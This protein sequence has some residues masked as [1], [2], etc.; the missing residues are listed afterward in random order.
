MPRR[1][2]TGTAHRRSGRE[3]GSSALRAHPSAPTRTKPAGPSRYLVLLLSALPLLYVLAVNAWVVDDAYITF[4]TVDNFVHGHGLTWNVD[5]R[6]QAYTHPL[7]MMLM[8][9][10]YA[11]TRE[12]FYTSIGLS[13][14][15]TLL[16][17]AMWAHAFTDGF[18]RH[19]WKVPLFVVAFIAGKAAIDFAS[20]GLENPLSYVI[21]TLFTLRLIRGP[22]EGRLSACV[23][24]MSLAYLNRPDSV[25]MLLP[26]VIWLLW[27][28]ETGERPPVRLAARLL[29][30]VSPAIVWTLFSLVYYGFPFP[31]TAYAKS[32]TTGFP[33]AWRV[34]RGLEYAWNSLSW[35]TAAWGV[36]AAACVL[37]V[38]TRS[39]AARALLSG[40]LI[41]MV[42]VVLDLASTTHMSGRFYSMPLFLGTVLFVSLLD[43]RRF[44]M[45]AMATLGLFVLWS[46]ISAI[47]FGTPSYHAP[48]QNRSSID[49]KWYVLNEGAALIDW[50][51]GV[52]LPDHVWYHDGEAFRASS[53][54]VRVGGGLGSPA[55][56]YVGYAAG[57]EKFFIDVVGLSDPLLARLPALTPP[58]SERWQSGHFLRK[59]PDGYVESVDLNENLIVDPAVHD[60]YAVIR[61]VTRGPIFRW[62]RFQDIVRL[63]F[64]LVKA[65]TSY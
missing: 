2:S 20:S 31:N 38:R 44:G 23:F 25:V 26:A 30:S 40:I 61:N 27:R 65:P 52:P 45:A 17:V 63:N 49:T 29:V 42:A 46:P 56:G 51:P 55:I 62:D 19:L 57:P 32:L 59:V 36:L 16:A 8:T 47:K 5:E 13:W 10:V 3:R 33:I 39:A 34:Q 41:Y 14:V 15:L 48:A 1:R 58:S 24:W 64:G 43:S 37:A 12:A 9:S 28:R 18:R 11:V 22:D 6:V 35:D 4:R 50:R 60:Y 53:A 54:K 7:W 21:L